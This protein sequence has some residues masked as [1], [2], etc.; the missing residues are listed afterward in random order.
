MLIKHRVRRVSTGGASE[1]GDLSRC[2]FFSPPPGPPETKDPEIPKASPRYGDAL[3][4]P[5][6]HRRRLSPGGPAGDG[7]TGPARGGARGPGAEAP[8]ELRLLDLVLAVGRALDGV[9]VPHA[10]VG[11]L[12]QQLW[13][14]K[15]QSGRWLPNAAP[16]E[17]LLKVRR[18]KVPRMG[19]CPLPRSRSWGG[20]PECATTGPS[21]A[22]GP[23]QAGQE[24]R[25][26]WLGTR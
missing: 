23:Q 18:G 5:L 24:R 12:E 8:E 25:S 16:S 19:R 21:P 7:L 26:R 14:D 22:W 3:P 10:G 6:L 13:G 17:D 11:L 9:L 20:G 4:A 2:R 15:G 1:S